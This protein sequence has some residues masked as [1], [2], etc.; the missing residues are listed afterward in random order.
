MD[1]NYTVRL[2]KQKKVELDWYEFFVL[3]VPLCN[4]RPIATK[5]EKQ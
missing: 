2:P 1:A 3:E 4:L 5:N